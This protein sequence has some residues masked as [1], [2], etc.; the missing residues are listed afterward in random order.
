MPKIEAVATALPKNVVTQAQ[1][2]AECEKLYADDPRVL[3]LLRVFDSGVVTRHFAFPPEYYLSKRSFE[4]RNAD[5]VEQATALAESAARDCLDRAG[6]SADAVDHLFFVTTTGLATPSID[7]LLAPRLGLRKEARR[8]PLFGLGCAAGA[9]GLIRACEVLRGHPKQRALV[10]SVELCGQVFAMGAKNPTDIVGAALFGD[11]AAAVLLAGDDVPAAGPRIEATHTELFEDSKHI[12]GWDF[13]SDGMRLVL[14]KD[15]GDL[16]KR[17]LRPVVESFLRSAAL[18]L[19]NLD[20]WIL[21]P[22][23][24]RIIDAYRE[25]FECDD[26]LLRWTR[27][28][29]ARV[30]NLSSASVLFTLKD[31]L[32]EARPSAGEKGIIVALGPG[33]STE[34][35]VLGW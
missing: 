33:F 32:D 8:W 7:A 27:N 28:S 26:S 17:R 34:M 13:T 15:V 12:M 16:V 11:G 2:R 6:V 30:G 21:H 10:V 9:G 29:L 35:L 3:R 22:G 18:A 23:G 25:A 20:Y 31:V 24:R 14:S 1:A 4:E 19:R 5:Y